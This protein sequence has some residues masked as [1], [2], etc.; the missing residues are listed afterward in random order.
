MRTL[1]SFVTVLVTLAGN[2]QTL[3][4]E[5]FEGTPAFTLNTSDANSVAGVSNSWVVNDVYAGGT[6]TVDCSGFVLDFTIPGTAGQPAEVSGA[7]G[8]YLHTAS[9][10]ALDNDILNCSF[11]AADGFCTNADD[12]FARMSTDVSTIGSSEV[13]FVF[14]WLCN[15][16]NQNYGEV[17]YSTT[18]GASW[19]QV[20]V[21]IAQYRNTTNWG[22]QTVTLPAFGNQPTLRFGF[23]FHNGESFLGGSDPGFAIDDVRI[24]ATNTNPVSIDAS[25]SPL[26]YCQG[27]SLNVGCAIT[28]TFNAGN[29]FTAEISDAAGSFASPMVI[30]SLA[31]TTGGSIACVI[32]PGMPPGTGYRVRVVSSSP[33]TAGT[34]NGSDIIVY[35]AP[36]AGTD[37]ALT[38]CSGDDPVSMA[39]G[40]DAGGTWTG[41]STVVG[42]LYDPAT[43]SPGIYTYTASGSGPCTSDASEV[44][45][46]E[47]AGANAGTSTV[48]V[49]CKET[50]I[51]DLFEFLEG[52]PDTGGTWTDPDGDPSD[53][54]FNSHTTNGGVYTYTVDPGGSCGA[55]EAV[56]TVQ[57]GLPGEA[58]PDDSWTVCSDALP[59]DLFDLLDGSANLTGV[60]FSNGV[61]FDGET[62]A[63]GSF[64]YIDYADQPC[65]NDTAFIT[66]DVSQ[67]AYAGENA[68]AQVCNDDPPLALLTALAGAPQTDGTWTGPDGSPHSGTFIPGTDAFGL[69]TYTVDAVEPCDA[70]EAVLAVVLCEVGLAESA[71]NAALVWLGQEGLG[72][73]VFSG[74]PLVNVAIEVIDAA[75][76]TVHSAASTSI[77]GQYR[78]DS[79]LLSAGAYTLRIRTDA[80]AAGVRFVQ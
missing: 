76:R 19:Q 16:G 50:G 2:A 4:T 67:A 8:N 11:G 22:E 3:F 27:A 25:V 17:Y 69:Y 57:I 35:E 64:V 52:A 62:A 30:G 36:Y 23:R 60:W 15:G 65:T 45:V 63:G 68:T 9:L 29:V 28:G 66:L 39:T 54:L 37:A 44:V 53:G 51:Y 1:F 33:V 5:D 48:A 47:V 10:V 38:I 18:S 73:H 7:N 56:V 55:D 20:T 13:S 79:G 72:Q 71:G 70:D 59:V 32:P 12:V 78:L 24:I 49:I 14:W 46:T 21:P 80:G 34:D 42:D 75:G 6:G 31:S 43:M 40:G 77:A 41:P 26:D 61:P 58:G 74:M